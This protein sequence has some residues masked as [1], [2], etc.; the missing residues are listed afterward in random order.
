MLAEV[1][2]RHRELK[3]LHVQAGFWNATGRLVD[4]MVIRQKFFEAEDDGKNGD[5]GKGK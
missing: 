3:W 5:G 1:E 4:P 2:T